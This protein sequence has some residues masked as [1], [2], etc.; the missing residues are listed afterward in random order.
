MIDINFKFY[1]DTPH[2][3]DPDQ[4][5]ETL[6]R[7]HA[8]LWSKP[9]PDGSRF[10]LSTATRG[11]YLHHSSQR[12]EFHLASDAIG[13]TYRHSKLVASVISQVPENELDDFFA[14]CSTIGAYTIF[15]GRMV[16]RK[17]T[18]NAARGLHPKVG[19]R[20]DL[21]LECIRRHYAGGVSPLSDVLMRYRD[22][23]NL[24]GSF[25][26]YVEFFLFQDLVQGDGRAINFFLPHTDFGHSPYPGNLG[27]Y[28][29]YRNA[30]MAFVAA[31]NARIAASTQIM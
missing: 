14:H 26:G 5:S 9:L 23:F 13:H 18:I 7:Y 25:K 3:R 27:T 24:F 11:A 19:D 16:N 2:G 20:F 8:L 28:R 10:M 29:A 17:P 6:R 30:V 31:R 12:G 21:T 22:F 15:P 1:S 4:H